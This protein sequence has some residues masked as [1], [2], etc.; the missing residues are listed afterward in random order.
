MKAKYYLLY[1]IMAVFSFGGLQSCSDEENEIPEVKH[2]EKL[3]FTSDLLRVKIGAEN[4]VALPIATGAGEYNAYSLDSEIADVVADNDGYVYIEGYKNGSTILVVSDAA[5]NY[6]RLKIV[7]Y[8]IDELKLSHT[9]F[10]FVTPMGSSST[11]ECSVTLGNG[12]Y[13]V[14]SDND[15]VVPEIDSESGIITLTATSGKEE[16]I[17]TVTVTDCSSLTATIKV[18]VKPTFE[19]FTQSDIDMIL[20]K[21]SND[22]YIKSSQFSQ[23]LNTD[24][25]RYEKYGE[26]KDAAEDGQYVFGWW[27]DNHDSYNTRDYGGHV[28]FYPAET[29]L[30]QEVDAT[31]QFKYNRGS[32]NPIYKLE[33]K[34]KVIKDDEN[35]KIVIWWNVDMENECIN[36]GWIIRH[37]SAR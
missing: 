7:V 34:A 14:S 10:N 27:E 37:K 36:R 4:R 30:N 23:T 12:G 3:T 33:G 6:K 21:E 24:L 31:Y 35:V 1:L 22:W 25:P 19:A 17:A 16:Y 15:K 26:W 8:T 5:N 29:T 11:S 28:I 18:N 13:S 2:Q 20:A 9:E 32:S